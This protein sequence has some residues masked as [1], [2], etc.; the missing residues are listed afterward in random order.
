MIAPTVHTKVF[1]DRLVSCKCDTILCEA[2]KGLGITKITLYKLD[3]F[4][5]FPLPH[6]CSKCEGRG[7]NVTQ[8]ISSTKIT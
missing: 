7:W 8:D 2:C 5:T 3:A 6:T 4:P 1:G